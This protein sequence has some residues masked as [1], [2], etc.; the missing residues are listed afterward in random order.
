[1]LTEEVRNAIGDRLAIIEEKMKKTRQEIMIAVRIEDV[2][3]DTWRDLRC[4]LADI[5]SEISRMENICS[6]FYEISSRVETINER[7]M[8]KGE[9]N[10]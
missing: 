9:S 7:F 5:E 3:S 4:Q 10:D 6:I 2:R 8:P 1:M